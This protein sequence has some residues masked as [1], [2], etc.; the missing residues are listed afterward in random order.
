MKRRLQP[1]A[2]VR[3]G[4]DFKGPGNRIAVARVSAAQRRAMEEP[5]G[6]NARNA[7]EGCRCFV[8]CTR[9]EVG[10]PGWLDAGDT[11]V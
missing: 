8:V 11:Q 1:F 4:E 7:G 3:H 9:M 5:E 2:I 6:L 10:E